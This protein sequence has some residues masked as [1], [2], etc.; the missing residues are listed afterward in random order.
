[1]PRLSRCVPPRPPLAVEPLDDVRRHLL[2]TKGSE[3][4]RVK[5]SELRLWAVIRLDSLHP[6]SFFIP[7]LLCSSNDGGENGDEL[8]GLVE[9]LGQ[10]RLGN[11]FGGCY[12]AKPVVGFTGFFAGNEE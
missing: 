1:M 6:S 10:T 2:Q 12:K 9:Q 7:C 4:L 5:N 8:I 11:Q 3:E